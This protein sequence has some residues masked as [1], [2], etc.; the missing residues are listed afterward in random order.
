[1]W[2]QKKARRK[3]KGSRVTWVKEPPQVARARQPQ[4]PPFVPSAPPSW[5]PAEELVVGR[6]FVTTSPLT[7]DHTYAA[8]YPFPALDTDLSFAATEYASVKHSSLIVYAGSVRVTESRWLREA[9]RDVE[10]V[11]H[12]FVT[13]I[14]MC[15]V[16][17]LISMVP[18]GW[19][20]V[21]PT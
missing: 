15:I 14:G 5:D 6:A 19:S 2:G 8:S 16:H 9:Y 20:P 17:H 21:P 11:K 18:A 10:A 3:A 4:A 13:P 12:M 1:M 7:V